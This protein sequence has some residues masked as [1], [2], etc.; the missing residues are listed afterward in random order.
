MA[1]GNQQRNLTVLLL[2]ILALCILLFG[3]NLAGGLVG[4]FQLG[5]NIFRGSSGG[6]V[7]ERQRQRAEHVK[8]VLIILS[9]KRG[10]GKRDTNFATFQKK[11]KKSYQVSFDHCKSP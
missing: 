9:S 2:A 11:R 3:Q 1:L 8:K 10:R 5:G 7:A 6:V 4:I